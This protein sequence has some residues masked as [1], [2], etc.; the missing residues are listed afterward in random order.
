MGRKTRIRSSDGTSSDRGRATVLSFARPRSEPL[1]KGIVQA[2]LPTP[3]AGA[4]CNHARAIQPDGNL[5]LGGLL[6]GS[7]APTNGR[8]RRGDP[9]AW[10]DDAFVP[11]HAP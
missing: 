2:G 11:F 10:R 3:T 1:L 8:D 4:K 5:L 6:V 9:A 7:A